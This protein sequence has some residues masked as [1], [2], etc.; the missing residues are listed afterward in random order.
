MQLSEYLFSMHKALGMTS[1]LC[2]YGEVEAG[3]SEVQG[4]PQLHRKSKVSMDT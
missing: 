4:Y 2:K 3:G 1:V